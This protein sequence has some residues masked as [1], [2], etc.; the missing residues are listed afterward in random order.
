M[1]FCEKEIQEY[2]WDHKEKFY[3]MIEKPVFES[4]PN[5]MPY[6]Y[7]P[8]ELLYYKTL[9][10]YE[11]NF[12]S[13]EGL[14][15]FGREVRL[16][17][18]GEGTIRT[19]FLGCF[20]GE[21]GLVICE[22]KVNRAPERQ[23]YTEL[24]GYA[25]HVRSKFAPMGRLD[26]FYLLISPME[27]RILREATITNL[28]Y[29]KNRVIALIPEVEEN[30][31]SLKF[32]VWIPPKE[33]FKIFTKTAFAFENIDTFKISWRGALGKWSPDQKGKDPNA[34]MIHQLNKVSHYAAQIMEVNGING[35]VYCSQ[36]YPTSRDL[37]FLE[38]GI[39]ICGINPFKAAKTRMLYEYG[40]SIKDAAR[41]SVESFSLGN[42]FPSILKNCKEANSEFNYWEWMDQSWLSN[43]EKIAFD[44]VK[45]AN[46]T[47]GPAQFEQGYGEFTWETYLNR[48]SEDYG[49]WNYD[50]S[51]TGLFREIYDIKL[52]RYYNAVDKYSSDIKSRIME[53]GILEWHGIDMMYSQ[54][55]IRE[56]IRGLI[57]K[58]E[59][60]RI[61][62][63]SKEDI[64]SWRN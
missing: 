2:I 13:L 15:L 5:K 42:I 22:L 32:K 48:S 29:D 60:D 52:E 40:Y 41:L 36:L 50:T 1:T 9:K 35:F 58:D 54:D 49:C 27:E 16:E 53:S 64:T 37:G 21:N 6:E 46:Q 38:N 63:P 30:I 17:K 55:H 14:V 18:S 33:E 26:V 24:F 12:K 47:F 4:D 28:L 39:T 62:T 7:E 51:L 31:D 43:I 25:N 8:W 61:E 56:F 44:V 19:D 10:E 3:S 11:E 45:K 34:E 57:G 20:E 23:A 59:N